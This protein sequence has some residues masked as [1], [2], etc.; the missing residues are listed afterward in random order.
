[1]ASRVSGAIKLGV[2]REINVFFIISIGFNWFPGS[3]IQLPGCAW[4]P[5]SRGSASSVAEENRRQSLRIIVP[6]QSRGTRR[7]CLLD[8]A[9]IVYTSNLP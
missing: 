2:N 6:R 1:M 9:L 7:K 5:I 4:E 3:F 8:K